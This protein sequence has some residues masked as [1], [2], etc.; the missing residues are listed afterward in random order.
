[1][2]YLCLPILIVSFLLVNT[3]N[4][5]LSLDSYLKG[6]IESSDKRYETMLFALQLM[7]ERSA[8]TIVE[9]GTARAGNSNFE[10]D[11]GFTII[12]GDYVRDNGG[13]FYSVDQNIYAL[14]N[15]ANGLGESRSFVRLVNEESVAFLQRFKQP[16][17]FLY[18]DS[19]DLDVDDPMP[20]Q[21]HHLKEIMAAY[22]NLHEKSVVMIDDCGFIHS[23]KGKQ[24]IYYLVSRGWKILARGY[25]VILAPDE[26]KSVIF[27]PEP[28]S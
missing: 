27:P 13:T 20:S 28:G 11:G 2:R 21:Q 18:L 19:S 4:A 12:V 5:E 16:I 9:T 3:A 25:Q 10:G 8:T 17:D 7:K 15:A 6:R 23:G 14:S 1:M 22:P 24:V 26:S